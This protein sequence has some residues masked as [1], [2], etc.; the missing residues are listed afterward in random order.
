MPAVPFLGAL[1][2]LPVMVLSAL[3]GG[4]PA[5]SNPASPAATP[6][7]QPSLSTLCTFTASQIYYLAVDSQGNVYASTEAAHILKC[8]SMGVTSSFSSAFSNT[9]GLAVDSSDNLYVADQTL[10]TVS[11]I[12]S[13]G[14]VSALA[15]SFSFDEPDALGIN[16]NATTLFISDIGANA[17]DALVLGSNMASTVITSIDDVVGLAL[18]P[19]WDIYLDQGSDNS[20][21]YVHSSLSELDSYAGSGVGFANG[22]LTTAKFN[23]PLQIAMDSHANIYVA[24]TGNNAIRVISTSGSTVSTLVGV[25][26]DSPS[27]PQTFTSNPTGVAVDGSGNV[28]IAAGYSIYK[29]KP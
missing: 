1:V 25:G 8:T 5:K 14:T 19:S 16:S 20:F 7:P 26:A 4:C 18:D 12:T 28:Y 3:L 17:I 6:T 29:Y 9:A 10:K 21:T 2:L 22:S 13:Q 15:G 27:F 11:K 23:D 24:D